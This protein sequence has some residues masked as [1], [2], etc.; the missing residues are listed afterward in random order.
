MLSIRTKLSHRLSCHATLVAL[1]FILVDRSEILPGGA[2][3]MRLLT[4]EDMTVYTR[5]G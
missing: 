4:K 3:M 2:A 5:T 1:S